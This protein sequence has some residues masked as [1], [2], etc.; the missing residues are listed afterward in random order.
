MQ[1]QRRSFIRHQQINDLVWRALRR[2]DTPSIKE[3]SGL[4]PGE[5]KHP[6]RLTLVPRQGG[7]CFAWGATVVDTLAPSYVAVSAQV[8]GSEAQATAERKVSKYADLP[9][10]HLFVPIAI[11]TLALSMKLDTLFCSNCEGVF[12]QSQTILESLSFFYS[13]S[14]FSYKGLMRSHS[15]A[16]LT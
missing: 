8:T 10:S 6:D 16:L 12:R 11:E 3:P 1:A 9:A 15:E 7:H 4:L 13:V 14:P 2:A 5:D